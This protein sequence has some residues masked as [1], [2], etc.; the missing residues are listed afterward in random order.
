M[1]ELKSKSSQ[2]VEAIRQF[3][4]ETEI[5]SKKVIWPE[6]RYVAAA[7]IIVLIIVIVSAIYVM[8]L[9]FGFTE[10]FK[11]LHSMFGQRVY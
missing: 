8:F 5:E 7:T 9:D 1:A 2:F 3:L 4:K 10:I 11:F 6:R